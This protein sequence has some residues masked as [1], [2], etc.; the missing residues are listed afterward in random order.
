M[1]TTI[2]ASCEDCGD[3]ELST[4]DLQVRVCSHDNRGTYVFRCPACQMS[5]V[6]AAESRIIDLL[7]A[8]GVKMETWDLPAELSE[9]RSSTPLTHDDLIDFHRLLQGDEWF[10]ALAST[11]DRKH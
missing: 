8:S 4:E 3:V 10:D 6:K 5:V 1:A 2:R 9:P 11:L 7:I